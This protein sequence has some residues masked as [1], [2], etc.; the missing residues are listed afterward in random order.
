MLLFK[1]YY[2]V[3]KVEQFW[4]ALFIEFKY[5]KKTRI[6]PNYVIKR[7][8]SFQSDIFQSNLPT[9]T[10][11]IGCGFGRNL[12]Y[13]IENDFSEQY[14]GIDLTQTA[15]DVSMILWIRFGRIV[16]NQRR[17]PNEPK[18]YQRVRSC[19]PNYIQMASTIREI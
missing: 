19:Q 4:S 1:L 18:I 16:S 8:F 3:S 6:E 15:I 11:E 9:R 12:K 17:C 2:F 7:I 14:F 10:L 13:F 5:D